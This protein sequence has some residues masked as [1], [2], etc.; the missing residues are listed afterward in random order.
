MITAGIIIEKWKEKIF[1]RVLLEHNFG[2]TGFPGP[3]ADT[4]LLK[5]QTN[6][7]LALK[8]AVENAQGECALKRS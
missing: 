7:L 3:F 4:I 2:V 6:D 8:S 1:L 5:I